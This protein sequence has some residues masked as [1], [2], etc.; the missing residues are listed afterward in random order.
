MKTIVLYSSRTGNTRKVAAEIFAAIPGENKDM[1]NLNEYNGKEADT[2]FVG[3]WTDMGTCELK[4]GDLLSRL[5]GKN[6]ALFGT[7]GMGKDEKY[8]K[9]VEEKVKVWLPDNC[10][11]LGCYLCQGKMPMQVRRRY[12]EMLSKD[13]NPRQVQKM[14]QNFDEALLHPDDLDLEGARSFVSGVMNRMA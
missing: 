7:C 5:E 3:F 14:I 6:I 4:V 9:M 8:Y 10:N 11:Y 12:E 13:Q 1:Q 2:F